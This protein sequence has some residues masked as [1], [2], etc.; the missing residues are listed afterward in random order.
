MTKLAKIIQAEIRT[1][2]AMSFERFMELAL[3]QPGLGY[4]VGTNGPTRIG[5][6]GDFYTS[7]SVGPLFGRLLG[8]QFFQM[9]EILGNPDPFWVMEQGAHDGQ[10]ARDILEW[11]EAE[12]P[13]FF[14]AMHYAVVGGTEFANEAGPNRITWFE[15]LG[16]LAGKKPVGVVFSNEL[17]DAFPVRVIVGR[18]GQWKERRV[19]IDENG[20]FGWTEAKMGEELDEAATSLP[21]PPL[22]GYVTEIN[23]RARRWMEEVAR[24]MSRGY[25]V[26]IDYGFPASVYYAPFRTAGTLTAYVKHRRVDDVLAEPGEHDLTAHVDFT[27]LARAGEKAGLSTLGFVDQQRFLMG[28]AHDELSGAAGPNAG[29]EKNQ[30]AWNTLTHPEH[31]GTTFQVL[32]QA[33]DAPAALDGLRFARPGGLTK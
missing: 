20:S 24:M 13:G 12:A 10:L 27:A 26:T 25:V 14:E 21:L 31:L 32:V 30:A 16:A 6:R 29:I 4:Y 19:M 23:L 15:N 7:V 1:G 2:G 22:E 3:Y 11:A 17:V 9:W 18:E 33:K 28:I 5:R 8:R